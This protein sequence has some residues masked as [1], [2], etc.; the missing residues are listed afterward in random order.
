MPFRKPYTRPAFRRGRK[1]RYMW[2][3]EQANDLVTASPATIDL[4]ANYR[5]QFA[6]AVNL[7]EITVWRF[8]IKIS[9]LGK[10]TLA[11]SV[12]SSDGVFVACWVDDKTQAPLIASSASYSQKYLVW[13]EIYFTE[14]ASQSSTGF[15]VAAANEVA[16]FREYDVKTHRKL[17]NLNDSL[18]LQ[19]QNLEDFSYDQFSYTSRILLRIT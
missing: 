19:L 7:P 5:A 8:H 9:I 12:K 10:I 13:E 2:V 6:I 14:G 15:T 3:R 16:L 4:L 18:F 17:Y 11:G 1:P